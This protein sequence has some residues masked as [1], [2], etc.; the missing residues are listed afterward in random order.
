MMRRFQRMS[1]LPLVVACLAVM[2]PSPARS[3][4]PVVDMP[5]VCY[6]CH[7]VHK[8]LPQKRHVHQPYS[9]G[10]CTDCHNPHASKHDSLLN[11]EAGKLC[12]SC[13]DAFKQKLEQKRLHRPV[14]EGK[15][16][17]CHEI[18]RH[19]VS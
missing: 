2:A 15:C 1:F 16:I 14:E 9:K 8:S 7:E 11:M 6:E 18:F 3:Q 5:A 12:L 13:H 19:I 4:A 17:E 10:H